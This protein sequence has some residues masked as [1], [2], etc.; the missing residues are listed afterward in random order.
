MRT[1][2]VY[3]LLQMNNGYRHLA[4]G[5]EKEEE[6]MLALVIISLLLII[7][8]V[9]V[10]RNAKNLTDF[11]LKVSENHFTMLPKVDTLV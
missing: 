8:V 6:V 1:K 5:N 9:D 2:C 11:V 3:V 4:I 7:G 10:I